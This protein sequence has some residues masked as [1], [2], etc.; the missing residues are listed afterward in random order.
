[1]PDPAP[2]ELRLHRSL[3]RLE[4]VQAAVARFA[5]LGR[6]E[7]IASPDEIRV[8]IAEV[9]ER[10]RPRMADEFANHA[11]FQ[12]ITLPASALPANPASPSGPNP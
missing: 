6:F 7:L 5:R 2:I 10:L 12:T 4:A 3:Y 8:L 11:L 1:M 9:P